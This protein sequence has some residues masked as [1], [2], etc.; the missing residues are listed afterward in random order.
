MILAAAA[1]SGSVV[2]LAT[3][4]SMVVL[5]NAQ[6]TARMAR[7]GVM[8][9]TG[10]PESQAGRAA[11]QQALGELG[12]VEGRTIEIQYRYGEG[13]HE[14]F[15]AMAAE[16]VHLN[17]DLIL[18][19]STPGARAAQ[20]ATRTIPIVFVLKGDPVENG[21]VPSL[22]RPAGNITGVSGA[23]DDEFS[24][25]FVELLRE[26]N[27]GI[28][29]MA[30]LRNPDIQLSA[31][32]VRNMESAGRALGI[33]LLPALVRSPTELDA[34]F[35]AMIRERAGAVIVDPTIFFGAHYRRVADL[36]AK[37][38]LPAIYGHPDAVDVG[39]LMSYAASTTEQWRRAAHYV[40]R[41]LKGT[42]PADLPVEVSM[43][44][45]LAINLRAA[46]ALGLTL[47]P[48]LLLRADRV[49]E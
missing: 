37:H 49:I 8:I 28:T 34:A 42:R 27:P 21:L 19:Q 38:R 9:G 33:R 12:H 47:P 32:Y 13:R 20:S 41:I 25:K 36:A 18:A 1:M 15:Q 5:A 7:I 4:L 46:R 30:M 11:F 23:I 6:P 14:R 26:A 43:R 24:G 3:V 17:V 10:A 45:E 48:S 31:A 16:M 44:F 40:D 39:G 22:A 29:R 2:A 35:A